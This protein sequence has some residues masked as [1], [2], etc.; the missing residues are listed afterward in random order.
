MFDL[1]CCHSNYRPVCFPR[2]VAFIGPEKVRIAEN[3]ARAARL[4]DGLSPG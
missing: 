1:K 3:S 4:L 2:S